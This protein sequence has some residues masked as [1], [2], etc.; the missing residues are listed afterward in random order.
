[1]V[2][3]G[4]RYYN[5]SQG[6]F[7]GR[8]PIEEKGGL[9]LYGFCSND[10]INGWD[11]LGMQDYDGVMDLD[12][13]GHDKAAGKLAEA[14]ASAQAF[15]DKL[16]RRADRAQETIV[17]NLGKRPGEM[18]IRSA[19]EA[20]EVLEF[21]GIRTLTT[22]EN[23]GA[24]VLRAKLAILAMSNPDT[25]QRNITR[26]NAVTLASS[27]IL[28]AA[29]PGFRTAAPIAAADSA[30]VAGLNTA[31][32]GPGEF[33]GVTESMSARAAAYQAQITGAPAGTAYLLNGVKFDGFANG[34][35]QEAKGAGY[36]WAVTEQ[37]VF[38]AGF[39]GADALAAQAQRQLTAAGPGA[40]I[41]WTFA[42]EAAA[43]ATRALFES[44]GITGIDIRVVAPVVP[45]GGG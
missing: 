40:N 3:Y 44:R 24:D 19:A 41:Q 29:L 4:R 33:V 14:R 36:A 22:G 39:R 2:Y 16:N 15:Q 7:L 1:L 32:R 26:L 42:E 20:R 21:L 37:G 35:L 45:D 6:R 17:E 9:N 23:G 43:N 27:L 34:V 30:V 38:R 5:P 10:A 11:Y 13:F 28:G 31:T 12:P 25:Y 18:Q 8:D